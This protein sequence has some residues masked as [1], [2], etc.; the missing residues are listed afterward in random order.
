M[1][2]K[3]QTNDGI[4][5]LKSVHGENIKNTHE[6][7]Y[8][9]NLTRLAYG[10]KN[11]EK[12]SCK[13][14]KKESHVNISDLR[15][16]IFKE[17][18]TKGAIGIKDNTEYR[19]CKEHINF[20]KE[21]GLKEEYI[22]RTKNSG[23]KCSHEGCVKIATFDG[24]KFCKQH[25]SAGI[26]DDKRKCEIPGCNLRPTWGLKNEKPTVCK[27]HKTDG[28]FSRRICIVNDCKKS[29]M[30]GKQGGSAKYCKDHSLE[31]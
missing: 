5:F 12:I 14:H 15:I 3:Y 31:S 11:G 19:F 24:K 18:S 30:F 26:S 1:S 13:K 2:K 7:C 23:S 27:D 4:E 10:E 22:I 28:M 6:T 20:L 25:S 16:C 9:C 17:C 29:A 8:K 21:N